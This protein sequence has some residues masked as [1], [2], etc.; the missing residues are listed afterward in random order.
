LLHLPGEMLSRVRLS[1]FHCQ[2]SKS[3]K[4]GV[5]RQLPHVSSW[6]NPFHFQEPR[7]AG[8]RWSGGSAPAQCRAH[9]NL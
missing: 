5:E 1:Q 7:H 3:W 2:P 9:H 4:G 6:T 8:E